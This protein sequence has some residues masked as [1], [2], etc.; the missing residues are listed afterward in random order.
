MFNDSIFIVRSVH[1][2]GIR[3]NNEVDDQKLEQ[4]CKIGLYGEP[5]NDL[6]CHVATYFNETS[7][8]CNLGINQQS[9][10]IYSVGVVT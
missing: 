6:I 2:E 5:D 1:Q 7:D 8:C 4:G 9:S 3:Q 10:S